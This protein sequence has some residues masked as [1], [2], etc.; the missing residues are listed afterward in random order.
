VT[1]AA[2]QQRETESLGHALARY[3]FRYACVNELTEA[4]ERGEL[5]TEASL[6]IA[7]TSPA[8]DMFCRKRPQ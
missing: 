2:C 7:H 5:L 6:L 1:H 3:G 4:R 8:A